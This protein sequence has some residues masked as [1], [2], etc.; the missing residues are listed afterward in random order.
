MRGRTQAARNGGDGEE[1][2]KQQSPE[3]VVA[4]AAGHVEAASRGLAPGIFPATTY[5]RDPDMSLPGGAVYSRDDNPGFDVAEEMLCRLERGAEAMLFASGM[6]A[7]ASLFKALRHGNR[8]ILPRVMYFALQVWVQG[9]AERFGLRV[10]LVGNDAADYVAALSREPARLVWVETP[11]NPLWTVTDI[12][13]VAQACRAC[14]ATL[15]VDNTV[16]TPVLT[17][18]LELGADIVMHSATKALNGHSDVLAGALVTG[19]VDDPLWQGAKEERR[20]AGAV[21]GPFEAWLL[22]RGMRTLFVRMERAM[23][24]AAALAEWLDAREDVAAVLYP[25]L[26]G[27]PG[28]AVAARQMVG[29]FGTMLSV[30]TGGGEARARAVKGQLTLFRR[31]TSLGGVESLVEHRRTVEGPTSQAPDDLLRLSVGIEAL[32]DLRADL[33]Q[34][35]SATAWN[36]TTEKDGE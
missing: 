13:A 25:G 33:A 20:L 15:A 36:E 21:I 27:H 5:E 28:H 10:E 19:N 3:T 22:A 34:A 23:Q 32:E 16:P 1:M 6:A 29:G 17:R 2:K 30:R 8:V 26:P 7:A 12:A 4:Q 11:S 31:A 24:N 35:L 18:P 14:G 9:F